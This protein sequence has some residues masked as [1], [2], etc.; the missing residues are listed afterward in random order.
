MATPGKR[1][2]ALAALDDFTKAPRKSAQQE[3]LIYEALDPPA[4]RKLLQDAIG[5]QEDVEKMSKHQVTKRVRSL[6]KDGT[7]SLNHLRYVKGCAT[8]IGFCGTSLCVHVS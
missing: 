4:L 6:I 1:N 5:G 3:E 8:I 7:I 2:R